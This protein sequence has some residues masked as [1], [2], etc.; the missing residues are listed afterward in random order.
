[1]P[2]RAD[3]S[4]LQHTHSPYHVPEI[5]KTIASQTNPEGVA[6]RFDDPDGPKSIAVDGALLDYDD[7]LLRDWEFPLVTTAKPPDAHPC[8][9]LRSGPGSGNI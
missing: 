4:H 5:G 1:M 7:P 2:K 3:L 9:R 8:S 6:E